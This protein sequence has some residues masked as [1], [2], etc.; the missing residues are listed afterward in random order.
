MDLENLKKQAITIRDENERSANTASRVGR[1]MLETVNAIE[2]NNT[3]IAANA[4]NI[5]T[6]ATDISTHAAD[7]AKIQAFYHG[8]LGNFASWTEATAALDAMVTG[9]KDNG[10]YQIRI[11][12]VPFIVNFA[13]LSTGSKIYT[14]SVIGAAALKSD[15]T[16]VTTH[17]QA[18]NIFSRSYADSAWGAWTR[19]A[20]MSDVP[21]VQTACAGTNKNYIYQDIKDNKKYVLSGV[22]KA[23]QDWSKLKLCFKLWGSDND[24]YDDGMTKTIEFPQVDAS[25]DGAMNH[26]VYGRLMNHT[27][28]VG[29]ATTNAVPVNYTNFQ[30]GGNSSFTIEAASSAKAGVMTATQYNAL[31]SLDARFCE[32]MNQA[33]EDAAFTAL[34]DSSISGNIKIV[35][36]HATISTNRSVTMLQSVYNDYT[37]QIL[38]INDYVYQ[39]SIYFKDGNR[40]EVTYVSGLSPLFPDRLKWDATNHKYVPSQFGKEFNA[41]STDPIPTASATADGLMSKEDYTLL[42]KV[43]TQL[44]L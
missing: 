40:K 17:G 24:G 43:K 10:Q 21:T 41:E 4:A 7:I 25:S 13:C 19:L 34:A 35:V 30:N 32:L 33:S 11:G 2:E 23:F 9:P 26:D 16:L 36:A 44:N 18:V 29:N 12:S 8:D 42:Q 27:I 28:K 31:T 5:K 37:R 38:I 6:N 14:Q 39:R 3:A 20:A 1:A 22:A 15:G